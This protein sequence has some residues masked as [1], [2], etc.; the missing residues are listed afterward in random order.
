M[1]QQSRKQH[2]TDTFAP[3]LTLLSKCLRCSEL[4][5]VLVDS[6]KLA[7]PLNKLESMP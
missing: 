1:N 2:A 4:G 3:D 6:E 7:K 5:Q